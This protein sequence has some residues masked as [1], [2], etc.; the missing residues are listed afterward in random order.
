MQYKQLDD[1]FAVAGQIDISDVADIAAMGFKT[2]ISNRP[3][4]ESGTVPHEGI[5]AAAERAGIKFL[6]IPV[7]SGAMTDYDVRQMYLALQSA[8]KPVLAYCRTGAR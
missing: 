1:D 4:S 2:L 3:D 5:R 6:Y 8:P 7:S